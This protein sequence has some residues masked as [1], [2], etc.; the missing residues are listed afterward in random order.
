MQA[1]CCPSCSPWGKS[2]K[3]LRRTT[4]PGDHNISNLRLAAVPTTWLAMLV[5]A[6]IAVVGCMDS[7]TGPTD[8]P[9]GNTT[10]ITPGD[11]T[12]GDGG[13][14]T[15]PGD[16]GQPGNGDP[17]DPPPTDPPP[18]DP[19][20]SDPP[21]SDPPPS[22]PPSSD[23]PPSNPHADCGG[24]ELADWLVRAQRM[25]CVED[26]A[27]AGW[28][29]QSHDDPVSDG[30][31]GSRGWGQRE[32]L[33]LYLD[34][35]NKV[36]T[37]VE[38]MMP[39]HWYGTGGFHIGGYG[40]CPSERDDCIRLDWNAPQREGFR[41]TVY[42]NVDGVRGEKRCDWL[43]D[44]QVFFDNEWTRIT[45]EGQYDPDSGRFWGFMEYENPH[46]PGGRVRVENGVTVLAHNSVAIGEFAKW[47]GPFFP[48]GHPGRSETAWV[49]N[50]SYYEPR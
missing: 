29:Q 2:P 50:D 32:E 4:H 41:M 18:T 45:F 43:A 40:I 14:G 10:G 8:S 33:L 48:A 16:P 21:P 39:P 28:C 20:P 22:D 30:P 46:I 44:T 1:R 27:W 12:T 5:I 15:D 9:D 34:H 11:P 19:P 31:G 24:C 6:G 35:G 17:T 7:F 26:G 25:V 38:I 49:R 42:N 13:N 23:P 37:Q 36:G 3:A 47:G